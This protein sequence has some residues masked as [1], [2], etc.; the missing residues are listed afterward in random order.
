MGGLP[1]FD[2]PGTEE[3]L[4]FEGHRAL[5][6]RAHPQFAALSES[7]PGLGRREEPES[8]PKALQ[9][10]MTV[11]I[12]VRTA[13]AVVFAA[14]SKLTTRSLVGFD[15]KGHPEFLIQTYDNAIKLGHDV[16]KHLIAAVAGNG[17]LGNK[18]VIDHLSQQRPK[19][20]QV[21]D[22]NQEQYLAEALWEM[23]AIRF[24]FWTGLKV[25]VAQWPDTV[26]LTATISPSDS[27]PRVWRA[28]Y[29]QNTCVVQEILTNPGV[30]LEG[31]YHEVFSLLYGY[32]PQ[33]IEQACSLYKRSR[34]RIS[35]IFND[36]RVLGPIA[37]LNIGPM[38]IQDAM[39]LAYFL[40]G[41]QIEMDKFLPGTPVCGG[42]IDL[43]VLQGVPFRDIKEFPGK[44]LTHPRQGVIHK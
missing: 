23:G 40:A 37:R 20:A 18:S 31:S 44:Q 17:S 10:N 29:E 7:R 6:R 43:M 28:V 4:L 19:I 5:D 15:K 21:S 12:A 36:P 22:N 25:P 11:E 35:Q 27:R 41:V 3:V 9:S 39:D 42:S 33:V 26:V 30:Y 16:D 2:R 34:K 14:D 13:S 38:P 24:D 8:A 1:I 32:H